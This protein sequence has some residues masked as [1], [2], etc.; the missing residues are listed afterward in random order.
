MGEAGTT[1]DVIRT[2][3]LKVTNTPKMTNT[4]VMS[5]HKHIITP[6]LASSKPPKNTRI[7]EDHSSIISKKLPMP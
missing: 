7:K 6:T 2:V 1:M 5:T 3:T 4:V